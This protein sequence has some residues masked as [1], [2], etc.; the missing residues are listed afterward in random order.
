[1]TTS[2]DRILTT[3]VGSLPRPDDLLVLLRQEDRDE[4][5]DAAALAARVT[6]AVSE[7]VA[8]Q[9]TSDVDIVNDGEMSKISYHVYAKHRLSGLQSI[10]G[11]GVPGRPAPRD[12]LDFPDMAAEFLARVG[13]E[14]MKATVCKGP[15]SFANRAPLDR[16]I[17]NL[18]AAAKT[19]KPVGTFLSSV[20]PGCLSTY[21]PNQHYPSRDAYREALIEAL[22]PEYEAI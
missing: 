11:T 21:V 1:M 14:M 12:M 5:F 17:A 8:A 10:D 16:D 4:P 6:T 9:V 7:A 13:T 15:V 2:T 3:H 18:T 20:S 22:R 19:S